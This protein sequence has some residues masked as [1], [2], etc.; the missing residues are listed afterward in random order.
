[1]GE[2]FRNSLVR[3]SPEMDRIRDAVRE[4]GI[5]VVLGYS[6]RFNGSMYIAQVYTLTSGPVPMLIMLL[7][8]SLSL[9]PLVQLFIT[10]ARPSLHTL[11]APTGA[12]DNLKVS[13]LQYRAR[14][15]RFLV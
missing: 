15:A 12:M 11:N 2:Y 9:I 4:A 7:C 13:S 1:M 10:A 3:E 6:E 8:N 14:L 5:F